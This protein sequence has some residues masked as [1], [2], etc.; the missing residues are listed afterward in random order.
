MAKQPVKRKDAAGQAGIVA[1]G[2][3]SGAGAGA[4]FG[5]SSAGDPDNI[6]SNAAV[7]AAVGAVVGFIWGLYMATEW[8]TR[9]RHGVENCRRERG[10]APSGWE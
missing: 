1:A 9:F 6:G 4:L 7:G 2:T 10:Y 8:E 5:V 3:V